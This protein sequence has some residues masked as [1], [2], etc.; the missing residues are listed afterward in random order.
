MQTIEISRRAD[1]KLITRLANST[2]SP[3]GVDTSLD[4]AIGTAV[5]EATRISKEE[6]CAVAIN[7]EDARGQFRRNQLV[8]APAKINRKAAGPKPPTLFD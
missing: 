4:Q 1:G 3:L 2:D 7:V 6:K 8:R 5:R